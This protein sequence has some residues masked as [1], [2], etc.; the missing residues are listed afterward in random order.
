MLNSNILGIKRTYSA[1][2]NMPTYVAPW[3]T[4]NTN[5]LIYFR[6]I[7]KATYV[8]PWRVHT[9]FH[10]SDT[11]WWPLM[12]PLGVYTHTFIFQTHSDGHLCPLA[13]TNI[14][15]VF[16]HKMSLHEEDQERRLLVEH[17]L[18]KVDLDQLLERRLGEFGR[19]VTIICINFEDFLSLFCRFLLLI[20]KKEFERKVRKVLSLYT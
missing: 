19:F 6:H 15:S 16:R 12:L 5:I 2:A 1:Q 10:I 14:L 4:H 17:P 18:E 20:Y 11:F 9:Y 8:A 3:R 7:L 13:C